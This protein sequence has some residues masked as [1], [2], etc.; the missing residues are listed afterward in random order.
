MSKILE[1]NTLYHADCLKLLERLPDESIDLIYVDPPWREPSTRASRKDTEFDAWMRRVLRQYW[2]VLHRKGTLLVHTKLGSDNRVVDLLNE[3]FG[4]VN[5]REEIILPTGKRPPEARR[6]E[7]IRRYA[8]GSQNRRTLPDQIWEY[9]AYELDPS[10]QVDYE[11]RPL[12]LIEDLIGNTT[13]KDDLVLD[14]FCGTGTTLAAAHRLGRRWIGCDKYKTQFDYS[15]SRLAKEAAVSANGYKVSDRYKL[16]RLPIVRSSIYPTFFIS[17]KREDAEQ[18]VEPLCEKLHKDYIYFWR[19]VKSIPGGSRWEQ[20]LN[21]ALQTCDALI[22]FVTKASLESAWVKKEYT[23]F[24]ERDRMIYPIMCEEGVS[25]PKELQPYQH[26]SFGEGR[27]ILNDLRTFVP[28]K[29][30]NE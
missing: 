23:T 15:R 25:L 2:R 7:Y 8:K 3:A 16:G 21:K 28:S 18:F 30:H 10:F 9:P 22:L 6:Y 12:G 24:L 13:K 4:R 20:E 14:T 27:R 5:A 17:Y 26:I 29:A 11:V 19:D 1:N